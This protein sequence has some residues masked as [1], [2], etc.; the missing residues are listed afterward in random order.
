MIKLVIFD[1]DDTL[2]SEAEYVKSGYKAVSKYIE[3]K[4]HINSKDAFYKLWSYFENK[5]K[6]TFNKLLE[7]Y[8]I[9]YSK[10]DIIE[11]VNIYR[12]HKPNITF[13]DDVIPFLKELKSRKI[14]TGIISDGYVNTQR[15]KLEAVDA[16]AKFDYIILTDELGKEYWKPNP[17]AFEMMM[18]KFDLNPEEMIYVGDNPKKDFYIKKCL[19]IITVKIERKNAIYANEEYLENVKEDFR[20]N[21]L[22]DIFNFVK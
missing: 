11:L 2:I 13:F 7:E 14:S 22:M 4:F 8:E 18:E 20:T 16:Y 3:E 19:N 6:N 15:N 10:D 1:L 12:N 9:S 17:K 5:E 21:E